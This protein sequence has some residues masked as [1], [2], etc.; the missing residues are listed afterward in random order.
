M[1]GSDNG[2]ERSSDN[3][4]LVGGKTDLI[5][6][7]IRLPWIAFWP[8]GIAPG[9]VSA[10][11]CMTTDWSATMLD[12]AGVA[13]H[14]DYPLDGVSLAAVLREPSHRFHRPMYWR[15]KHHDER[16]LRD[17]EWQYLRVDD[18]DYP[19]DRTCDARE[20]A[21][22]ARCEPPRLQAMRERWESWNATMP[23]LP[24]DAMEHLGY[25]TRDMPQR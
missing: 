9:G 3:W 10:Q 1:F 8:A 7:G 11:H 5:E 14:P 23:A 24:D 25:S 2:G 20:R 16:A 18:N 15:M 19:F 4:P 13:A 6:G 21:D 12:L 22:K 17:G